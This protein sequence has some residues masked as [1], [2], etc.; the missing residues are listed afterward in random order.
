MQRRIITQIL[1]IGLLLGIFV[2]CSKDKHSF[3]IEGVIENAGDQMLYLENVGTTRITR[4]DSVKLTA[5]GKFRFQGERPATPEFYR[6]NLNQQWINIAIDSTETINV[7]G[8]SGHFAT[9][10]SIE[11]S[12]ENEQI[13]ALTLLLIQAQSEYRRLKLRNET[14]DLSAGLYAGELEKAL[15]PY[16]TAARQYIYSAPMSATAYF[17]LLQQIDHLLIFDPYDKADSKAFGAVANSWHQYYPESPR[18]TQLYNL[19]TSALAYLR[20]DRKIE[21]HE[22]DSRQWLD[23]LL[24]AIDGKNKVLS[25]TGAGKVTLIDFTSYAMKESPE[26]TILLNELYAAY[27]AKGFEI[28]QISVDPEEHFWKNACANL[29]WICVWD[30]QSIY[31]E[32]LKRYNVSEIP[33]SFIRD[34]SGEI[35]KRIESDDQLKKEIAKIML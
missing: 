30:Q 19:F 16:R 31:S 7:Q 10:Y 18:S 32:L 11:G 4:I 5:D 17:A 27:H 21:V 20:K 34:R 13:K 15:E 25:E 22:G 33:T 6:L 8:K 12:V 29:P 14:E 3:T 26:R 35:V 24:P 23:I 9:D 2:S 28:Y 1:S